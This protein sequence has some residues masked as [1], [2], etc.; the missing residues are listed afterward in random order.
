MYQQLLRDNSQDKHNHMLVYTGHKGSSLNQKQIDNLSKLYPCHHDM[1]QRKTK[2]I[3]RVWRE[4]IGIEWKKKEER[5]Q[6]EGDNNN[7]FELEEGLN[8]DIKSI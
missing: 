7:E 1:S 5:I 2:F 6:E 3:E 8:F 4:S